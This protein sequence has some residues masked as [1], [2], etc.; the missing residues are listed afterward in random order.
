MYYDLIEEGH[1]PEDSW[2][3]HA[4]AYEDEAYRERSK[5][6]TVKEESEIIAVGQELYDA[7]D[8][9]ELVDVVVEKFSMLPYIKFWIFA[10]VLKVHRA[11]G[12]DYGWKSVTVE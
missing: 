12:S 10:K 7:K 6:A 8:N 4:E 3:I 9:Q 11:D 2:T 5:V 1:K